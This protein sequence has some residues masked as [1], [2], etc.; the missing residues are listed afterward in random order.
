MSRK[1]PAVFGDTNRALSSDLSCGLCIFQEAAA[2][3]SVALFVSLCE[4]A[5]SW[6]SGHSPLA[7]LTRYAFLVARFPTVGCLRSHKTVSKTRFLCLKAIFATRG[8]ATFEQESMYLLLALGSV[9]LRS[10]LAL[11]AANQFAWATH[12][13]LAALYHYWN[14]QHSTSNPF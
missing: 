2:L 9:C 8:A 14:L 1:E 6:V 13:L 3:L 5:R 7:A 12:E 10:A 4:T 11:T